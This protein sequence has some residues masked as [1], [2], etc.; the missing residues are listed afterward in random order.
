M[1][2]FLEESSSVFMEEVYHGVTLPSVSSYCVKHSA[3]SKQPKQARASGETPDKRTKDSFYQKDGVQINKCYVEQLFWGTARFFGNLE[4]IY[5]FLG[6]GGTHYFHGPIDSK[7][8]ENILR[9][10]PKLLQQSISSNCTIVLFLVRLS[11]SHNTFVLSHGKS[12]GSGFTHFVIPHNIPANG[13]LT[14]E[15][16]VNGKIL[17]YTNLTTLLEQYFIIE[18]CVGKAVLSEKYSKVEVTVLQPSDYQ[19]IQEN[20]LEEPTKPVPNPTTLVQTLELGLS[21]LQICASKK[22]FRVYYL[23]TR[24]YVR[25]EVDVDT[26]KNSPESSALRYLKSLV[27]QAFET[28]AEV[29]ALHTL[30]NNMR[31]SNRTAL[32]RILQHQS[33]LKVTW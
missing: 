3:G 2:G 13:V 8:A 23:Q 6:N 11:I 28:P 21:K 9:Q 4:N 26:I 17:L 27:K 10:R 7:Q 22:V 24:E 29:Q 15:H 16:N 19:L 18:K 12:D 25:I 1:F 30:N 32:N 31:I 5:R 20:A 33:D 14:F